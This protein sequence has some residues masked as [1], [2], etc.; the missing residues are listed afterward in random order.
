[1][2]RDKRDP[3]QELYRDIQTLRHLIDER[4]LV[5]RGSP[6]WAEY[7]RREDALARTIYERASES[8]EDTD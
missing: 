7:D 3:D 2:D 8:K 6:E 5:E 4:A 1:V